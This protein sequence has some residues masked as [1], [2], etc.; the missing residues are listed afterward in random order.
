M[1]E[2]AST[3]N[4]DKFRALNGGWRTTFRGDLAGGITAALI[5][6]PKAMAL[7]ALVLSP[8]GPEYIST[9]IAAGLISLVTA[10]ITTAILGDMPIMNNSPFSLSSFML[11]AAL[12]NIVAAAG[13]H[14][15]GQAQAFTMVAFL[16]LTVLMSGGFQCVFGLLR[17]GDLAKYI[18]YPVLAG[19]LNGSA[20][21]IILSQVK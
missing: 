16:C 21:L 12:G 6:L 4:I 17:L 15:D 3:D 10:N 2:N 11:L 5:P 9:G 7:G 8:L 14:V 19:L 18:P 1:N 20:F 13:G